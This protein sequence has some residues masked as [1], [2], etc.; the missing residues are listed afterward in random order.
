VPELPE[1]EVVRRGLEE[2][3]VGRA[4][5]AVQIYQPRLRFPVPVTALQERLPGT[6]AASAGR[7]GKYLLLHLDSGETL[8]IHLGM[9]GRLLFVSAAVPLDKHDHVVFR[10]NGNGELRFRDPRRFGLVDLCPTAALER[11]PGLQ[12]LGPEP[13]SAEF[14]VSYALKRAGNSR[15]NIKSWLL[16]GQFLA[17]LGNIYASESLFRAG[18]HPVRP[19]GGLSAADWQ[20]L[21]S[22]VREVLHEAIL[23]GGTT[24]QDEGFRNILNLGGR[25][26]LRLRVYGR[27]G[28]PCPVCGAR[29]RRISQQGRSSYFCP[30]CQPE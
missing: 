4:F 8:L 12:H 13:F 22:S 24:L 11:H 29:I 25:F 5:S 20:R 19:A 21:I 2:G 1:V 18:I 26:Q 30:A 16:D 17:G 6:R 7:R 27:E 10:L 9:S 15:R 28:A 23:Q 14:S 3:V